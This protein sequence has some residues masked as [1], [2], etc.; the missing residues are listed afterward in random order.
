[1][2]QDYRSGKGGGSFQGI[3]SLLSEIPPSSHV[4]DY[5]EPY[6]GPLR[7]LRLNP[8]LRYL[9]R[10]RISREGFRLEG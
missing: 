4:I 2:N 9:K 7:R 8:I 5:P 6:S 10:F 3:E 1:M